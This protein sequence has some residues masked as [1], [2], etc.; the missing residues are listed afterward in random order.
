MGGQ[1]EWGFRGRLIWEQLAR[2]ALEHA[3]EVWWVGGKLVRRKLEA[4]QERVG[5]SLLMNGPTVAGV[6]VRG[7]FGWWSLEERRERNKLL[8]GRRWRNE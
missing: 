7:E 8:Y 4:V 5:R 2:P 6:A 3:A 1:S